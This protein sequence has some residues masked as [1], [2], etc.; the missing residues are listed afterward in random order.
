MYALNEEQ[1]MFRDTVADY[2]NDKLIP[3]REELDREK[4]FPHW[5][6]N[7]MVEMGITSLIIPED[8]D[9]LGFGLF[10]VGLVIEE[11]ARGCSGSATSLGATFLGTDPILY[12][13]TDEQKKKYLPRVA[14]GEVAAFS[15]TEPD[16]GSDAGGVK[17][18]ADRQE[19]GSY[20]IRGQKTYV[21]NGG[22][23]TIYTLFAVTDKTRGA[24]GVS[25]FI[26]DVDDPMNPPAGIEFPTKFDKM[27]INASETR[28]IIFDGFTI[29]KE[30]LI[31]G[32]EGRGFLHAMGTF[33]ATRPMIGIIGVGIA[34]AAFEEAI[35][36]V[37]ERKQFGK[38]IID[39]RAI[40]EMFVDMT[41]TVEASRALCLD[42]ARKVDDRMKGKSREDVT[43]LSGI[44]KVVGSEAGRI[45]LDALQ[46]TGGYGYMNETP[47]PKFVRDFKIFEIFEGTNQIQREQISLQ[48]V[49]DRSKKEKGA[50]IRQEA[51]EALARSPHCG[52][53]IV[54]QAR[55]AF[56][57]C[58]DYAIDGAHNTDQYRRFLLADILID[59]ET[60]RAF[61]KITSRLEEQNKNEYN[62]LACRIF[63]KE[64]ALRT[65]ARIRRFVI[66]TGGAAALDKIRAASDLDALDRNAEGLA[67]DRL[68]LS[69]LLAGQEL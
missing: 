10:D 1:E 49:K 31:G 37:Y 15:L 48:L 20:K 50:L 16:A 68:A 40:Q 12:F 36:Y 35:R 56:E 52:A 27:G 4:K 26:F 25:G 61:C 54:I 45:S 24:R 5:F 8:C 34:R 65:A 19:D 21:T 64:M 67:E 42:V 3:R 14:A 59:I 18:L 9:G 28:E 17:T 66:G 2:V 6:Y 55:N 38:R 47:F 33:D 63:G 11:I 60:A 44:A 23:A 57:G 39:F 32:K 7:D 46:T 53:Q 51:E 30:D 41:V 22:V 43:I 62:T 29:G 58:M 13:G 69:G